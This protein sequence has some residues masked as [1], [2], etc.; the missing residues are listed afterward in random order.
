ML[1]RTLVAVLLCLSAW[2]ADSLA[3]A[4]APDLTPA[5]G[6]ASWLTAAPCDS[7]S[8][9]EQWSVRQRHSVSTTES[10]WKSQLQPME[11]T[12]VSRRDTSFIVGLR[13]VPTRPGLHRSPHLHDTP[14]LI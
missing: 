9:D 1:R 7:E 3:I 2:A 6:T 14:L 11:L 13:G 4:S 10:G 5:A 8:S 12:S